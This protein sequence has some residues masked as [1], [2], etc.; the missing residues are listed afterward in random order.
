[1]EKKKINTI[2]NVDSL[3]TS[4]SMMPVNEV[5]DHFEISND[6]LNGKQ[7]EERLEK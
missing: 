5:Y 4:F 1:M 3:L 7:I 6:G 2:N